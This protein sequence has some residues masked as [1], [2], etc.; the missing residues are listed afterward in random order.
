[1]G[2]EDNGEP[3]GEGN[4][5]VRPENTDGQRERRDELDAG[6]R[7]SCRD[8]KAGPGEDMNFLETRR[9]VVPAEHVRDQQGPDTLSEG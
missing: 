9:E 6:T 2:C 7:A 4:I 3:A 1:V 5:E 8:V